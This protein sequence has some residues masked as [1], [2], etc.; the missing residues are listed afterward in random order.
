MSSFKQMLLVWTLILSSGCATMHF[1][2]GPVPVE[3]EYDHWHHIG[4]LRLV[5]FSAPIQLAKSCKV[6]Q[7][8]SVTVEQEFVHGLVGLFTFGLYD[9][10][11]ARH[12]CRERV[13]N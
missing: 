9:P 10:F 5:E 4:I 8:N 13:A 6:N 11:G 12:S 2:N 1:T 7:W 3:D